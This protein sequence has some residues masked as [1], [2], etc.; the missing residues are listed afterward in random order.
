MSE[1]KNNQNYQPTDRKKPSD[2]TQTDQ[3][4]TKDDFRALIV[5]SIKYDNAL[6]SEEKKQFIKEHREWYKSR[7]REGKYRNISN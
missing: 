1:D 4:I 7:G 2:E 5:E 6:T 3:V